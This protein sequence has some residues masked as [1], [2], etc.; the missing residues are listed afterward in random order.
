MMEMAQWN[1]DN[2]ALRV[3]IALVLSPG[4]SG[5]S[6][7]GDA[8][9]QVVA[10]DDAGRRQTGVSSERQRTGSFK[11][12]WADM[13]ENGRASSSWSGIFCSWFVAQWFS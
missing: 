6:Y 1:K 9:P 12:R 11:V 3:T 4:G 13:D 10:E 7:R 5:S 2:P 8:I